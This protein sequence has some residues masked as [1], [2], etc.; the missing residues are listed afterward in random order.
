MV[1]YTRTARDASPRIQALP[2]QRA[3]NVA[4][5]LRDAVSQRR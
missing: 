4:F 3:F 2:G 1:V 5:A